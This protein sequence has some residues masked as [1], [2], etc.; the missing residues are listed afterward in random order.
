MRIFTLCFILFFTISYAHPGKTD[1]N[2]GHYDKSIGEYHYHHGYPAHTMCGINCPYNNIDATNHNSSVS[3]TTSN[4]KKSKT[5]Q[6]QNL[7]NQMS[8]WEKI[9]ASILISFFSF[10]FTAILTDLVL[11]KFKNAYKKTENYIWFLGYIE[12]VLILYFLF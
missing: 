8:F 1:N 12:S 11:S 2:G 7:D 9:Y 4:Y 3:S 10:P 5:T 6:T